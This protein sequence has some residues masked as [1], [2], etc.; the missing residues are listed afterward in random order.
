MGESTRLESEQVAVPRGFESHRLLQHLSRKT[1]EI[2][3][4]RF[5]RPNCRV[6]TLAFPTVQDAFKTVGT[7]QHLGIDA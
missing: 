5:A 2:K 1:F 3:P 4:T 6:R 7:W